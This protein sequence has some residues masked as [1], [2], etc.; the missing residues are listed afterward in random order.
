MICKLFVS[1]KIIKQYEGD[2]VKK[3]KR[4]AMKQKKIFEV[5]MSGGEKPVPMLNNSTNQ[6]F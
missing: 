6:F 3:V 2:I 5:H 1:L 4:Q